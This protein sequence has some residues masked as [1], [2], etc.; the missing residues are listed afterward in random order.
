MIVV[1]KFSRGILA[2][3]QFSLKI[4]TFS[5]GFENGFAE[6]DLDNEDEAP[7]FFNGPKHRGKDKRGQSLEQSTDPVPLILLVIQLRLENV[8]NSPTHPTYDEETSNL[9]VFA[10]VQASVM[11]I[12][13]VA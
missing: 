3:C 7:L 5:S 12:A 10:I 11:C 13:K 1:A 2:V 9:S 6:T 4:A 8:E